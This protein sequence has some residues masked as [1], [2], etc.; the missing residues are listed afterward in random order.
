MEQI[1]K[2]IKGFIVFNKEVYVT[3]F[4]NKIRINIFQIML[5]QMVKLDL[6]K[7]T[8]TAPTIEVSTGN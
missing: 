8:R 5:K 7:I 1:T 2:L 3:D 4:N 6:R